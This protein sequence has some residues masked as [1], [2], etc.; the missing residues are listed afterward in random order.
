MVRMDKVVVAAELLFPTSSISEKTG[1]GPTSHL[2]VQHRL[3]DQSVVG[4]ARP[5]LEKR[6]H[7]LLKGKT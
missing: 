1:G 5:G 4:D 7:V 2:G 6:S 3:E